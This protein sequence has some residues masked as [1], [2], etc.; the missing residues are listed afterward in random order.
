MFLDGLAQTP[1]IASECENVDVSSRNAER[2]FRLD[3]A[4]LPVCRFQRFTRR[5]GRGRGR[6]G[7]GRRRRAAA[8]RGTILRP[9]FSR[10]LTL[11]SAAAAV[12]REGVGSPPAAR[13]ISRSGMMARAR[14]HPHWGSG[15][16]APARVVRGTTCRAG[17]FRHHASLHFPAEEGGAERIGSQ[18]FPA[19]AILTGRC[20]ENPNAIPKNRVNCRKVRVS[21]PPR[22]RPCRSP[23]TGPASRRAPPPARW[24]ARQVSD[25]P[26]SCDGLRSVPR[27]RG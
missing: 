15:M 8:L 26:S 9:T 10:A 16:T 13:K 2:V 6:G 7:A 17:T 4:Q 12:I 3:M 23:E 18:P 20:E 14:R 11:A 5:D 22:P 27:C 24:S 25:A 1:D 21:A 19:P